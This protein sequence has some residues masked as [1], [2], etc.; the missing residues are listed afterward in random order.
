DHQPWVCCL[1]LGLP[2]SPADISEGFRTLEA[3]LELDPYLKVVVI[4]GQADRENALQAVNQGAY[5]FFSKPIEIG[6]LK[7]V[8]NRAVYLRQIQEENRKLQR[9]VADRGSFEGMLG[10]SDAIQAVFSTVRK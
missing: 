7:V 3:M 10:T 2:P 9:G 8:L 1:D 4:T 6:S 5:D